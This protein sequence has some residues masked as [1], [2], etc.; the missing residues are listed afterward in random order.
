MDDRPQ[1]IENT[2]VAFDEHTVTDMQIVCFYAYSAL[3][4]GGPNERKSVLDPEQRCGA[5][6]Q[7][8]P[9]SENCTSTTAFGLVATITGTSGDDE[10]TGTPGDD[11]I[12]SGDGNDTIQ[13]REGNDRVCGG[14]G[15]DMIRGGSGLAESDDEDGFGPNPPIDSGDDLLDG[16]PGIDRVHGTGGND[17]VFGGGD[18]D[19]V[20]GGSPG[21]DLMEGG[22]GD[23]D[24]CS[25]AELPRDGGAGGPDSFGEGCEFI[26]NF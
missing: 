3:Y 13:G 18:H 19:S 26:N 16:G 21:S 6:S 10:I 7:G 23:N 14:A 1:T 4:T 17:R 22:P 25:R 5:T 9:E 12:V 24:V 2:S 11:V 8:I 15:D 20:L